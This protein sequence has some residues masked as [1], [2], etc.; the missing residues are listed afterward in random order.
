MKFRLNLFLKHPLM[1]VFAITAGSLPASAGTIWDGGGGANTDITLDANWDGDAAN[2]IDGTAAAIFAT[3]GSFATINVPA[4]FTTLTFN[5]NDPAGF[6]IGGSSV[7]SVNHSASSS[8]QNLAVSNTDSNGVTTIN[9]PLQVYTT[10]TTGTRLLNIPNSE[11]DAATP[12]LEIKGGLSAST[13]ANTF[14][15][16]FGGPG[17][18]RISGAIGGIS[19]VQQH[20]N[21]Q[22]AGTAIIAGNQALGNIAVN[23]GGTGSGTVASTARI[24]MG[25]STADVQSWANT[26]VNQNATVVINSTATLS[27]GI[28]ICTATSSGSTGGTVEVGGILSATTLRIGSN[29]YTGNLKVSGTAS[30]SGAIT[31]GTTAGNRIVGNDAVTAGTLKLGSGN[32]NGATTTLGGADSIED[33]LNLVKQGG[34]LLTVSGSHSYTGST[35]VEGGTLDLTGDI[36]SPATV[37]S[38][39]LLN[40]SGSTSAAVTVNAGGSIGGEGTIS[41]TLKFNEGASAIAFD[42]ATQTGALTADTVDVTAAGLIVVTPVSAAANDTPYVVLKRAAGTF[43]GADLAKFA[44]GTRGGALSLTGGNTEITITPAASVPASLIW[45]GNVNTAWDVAAT[46]NWLNGANPDRFYSGDSVSFNDDATSFAVTLTG[47]LTPGAIT[48]NNSANAYSITGGGIGGAGALTKSGTESVA[49]GSS[50]SHAGGIDVNAGILSIAAT[51]TFTGGINLDGGELRF[52]GNIA[53][54]LNTQP[55]TLNGG[56]ITYT[57]AVTMTNDAQTINV[58]ANGGGIK[59]DTAANI[60]WRIGGTISGS[61]NWAKSGAGVLSLGRGSDVSPANDFTGTLTVTGGTLDI[62]HGD[63]LGDIIAGTVIQNAVLLMQN[64]GQPAGTI[65]VEEPLAFSGNAYLTGYCQEVKSFTHEFNGDVTI[66][67]GATL[68]LATARSGS[69]T[70]PVLELKGSSIA[71]NAGS[72]LSLGLRPAVY[73]GGISASPQTINVAAPITGPG[74]VTAQGDAGSVFTL[75]A[76]GYSGDTT[77]ISGTLKLETPNANNQSS[78][79]SIASTGAILNL[80]FSGTD[81]V[82]KLVIGGV[83][84]PAGVYKATDNPDPGTGIA[85]ITG[86]GTLTVTSSPS[87]GY[88]AWQAANA[89]GQTVDQ[90]HDGD[91]VVNGIEYFM[92]ESGASFTAYPVLDATNKITWPMGA[93]YTGAYGTDYVVQTSADLDSW[94]SVSAGDVTIIAGSSVSYTLTGQGPRFVR[95]AVNPN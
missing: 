61:G 37:L 31:C 54:S 69:N 19:G 93:A 79:V 56:T 3:G 86:P 81:T 91:G 16:R 18:T 78:A 2:A 92:G 28:D 8:V 40:V 5:R 6:T 29:V 41:G 21:Q 27:A 30:F 4:R 46:Q 84:Q 60:T 62:R 39:G 7:L 47:T 89:P 15:L 13:P 25:E 83:Q 10:G 67:S 58:T 95:L 23:L 43:S 64:F 42:P 70:V 11:A 44:L 50:L 73:P 1:A 14:N 38:G 94:S 77:V 34:G 49:I 53:A 9:A 45:E 63:S 82:D 88:A 87:A 48:F 20:F 72:T 55:V 12:A 17:R 57:G 52:P 51:N 80:D 32:L 76:P 85:Q 26:V 90:D 75:G 68:G 65:V 33:N 35:T 59:T 36:A 74:A 24:E 71:T 66:A 22:M